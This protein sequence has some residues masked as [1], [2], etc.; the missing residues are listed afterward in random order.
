MKRKNR[1]VG[2]YVMLVMLVV[3]LFMLAT[4]DETL[5]TLGTLIAMFCGGYALRETLDRENEEE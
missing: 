4:R 3:V 1:I 2:M 5:T